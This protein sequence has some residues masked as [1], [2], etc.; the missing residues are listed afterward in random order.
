ME[1][2]DCSGSTGVIEKQ[3]LHACLGAMLN[4]VGEGGEA[5]DNRERSE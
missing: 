1:E 2:E 3:V 5:G 4:Y